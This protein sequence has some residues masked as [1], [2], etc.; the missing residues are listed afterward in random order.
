M[1]YVEFTNNS[2][3]INRL[4]QK[5][6]YLVLLELLIRQPSHQR[7][8]GCTLV[9]KPP[10]VFFF[11]FFFLRLLLTFER[12]PFTCAAVIGCLDELRTVIGSRRKYDTAHFPSPAACTPSASQ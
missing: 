6:H 10:K 1:E 12:F 11:F 2:N 3:Q 8:K 7:V 5:P 4:G 9:E